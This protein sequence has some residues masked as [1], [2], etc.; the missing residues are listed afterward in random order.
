MRNTKGHPL[1][2]SNLFMEFYLSIQSMKEF[3]SDR[4]HLHEW[5]PL[6]YDISSIGSLHVVKCLLSGLTGDIG[7][8]K[9]SY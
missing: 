2:E 5:V 9:E 8:V 7:I 3:I 4:R 6:L 1:M